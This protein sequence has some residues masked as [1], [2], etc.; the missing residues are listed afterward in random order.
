MPNDAD[1]ASYTVTSRTNIAL[2]CDGRHAA[3]LVNDGQRL[4]VESWSFHGTRAVTRRRTRKVE[5]VSARPLPLQ[6]GRT[7]VLRRVHGTRHELEIHDLDGTSGTTIGVDGTAVDAILSSHPATSV[8]LTVEQTSGETILYRVDA[9]TS[10]AEAVA[11]LPGRIGITGWLDEEDRD[12]V[13]NV[14]TGGGWRMAT[15]ALTSGSVRLLPAPLGT[16]VLTNRQRRMLVAAAHPAGPLLGWAAPDDD[17]VHLPTGL[18]GVPGRVLPLATDPSGRLLALRVAQGVRSRLAIHD[19][20]HDRTTLLPTPDGVLGRAAV[21]RDDTIRL[22]MSTPAQPTTIA[23]VSLPPPIGWSLPADPAPSRQL[24]VRTETFAGPAGAI[25]AI[26]YGGDWRDSRRVVVALHGGPEAAWTLEYEPTLRRLAD[27]GLTVVAP[28]QRGSDGY[29]P[30]HRDAIVGAW[31]GPD[32]ADIRWLRQVLTAGR[33]GVAAP[34]LLFGASYG[35]FLALLCA[36][37]DPQGWARCVAVAPFISGPR[38][39]ADGSPRVRRLVARL[40][41]LTELQDDLGPR[42][43]LRLG[44]RIRVPVQ[45]VHGARDHVVPVGHSRLLATALWP[46]ARPA[47]RE[48]EY[49]EV[50]DGGHYPLGDIGSGQLLER[51]LAFLLACPPGEAWSREGPMSA[52]RTEGGE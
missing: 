43:L 47:D 8:W 26:V 37:A 17:G 1:D 33:P 11:G 31:G 19:T 27:A 30:G 18:N 41:G 12:L 52:T 2:S 44:G 23:S 5:S 14:L 49:I 3:C 42:D 25:E 34:P 48:F 40:G 16:L 7:G 38:L 29:G 51:V 50:P 6:D 10:R 4:A 45:L 28:N 36:A 35:A 32:L 9:T 24:D 21:W 22:A 13:C 39:H 46:G 20:V 15:V